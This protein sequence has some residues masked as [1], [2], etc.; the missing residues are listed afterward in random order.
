[1]FTTVKEHMGIVK[2]LEGL[3]WQEILGF[4]NQE[5]LPFTKAI[6]T[7]EKRSILKQL[8]IEYGKKL[9]VYPEFLSKIINLQKAGISSLQNRKFYRWCRGN[10]TGLF[11]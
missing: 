4:S 3:G 10:T 6:D 7:D 5:L 1:M 9:V 11:L 8:P 2:G